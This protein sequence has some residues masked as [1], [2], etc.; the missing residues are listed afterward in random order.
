MGNVSNI[1]IRNI[2][3]HIFCLITFLRQSCRLCDNME[4]SGT[5]RQATGDITRGMRIAR[6][7]S[8]ATDIHS[9]HV[10]RILLYGKK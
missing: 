3:T 8:K 2:E 4:K 9:E 7:I 10:T 5:T 6:L 1:I